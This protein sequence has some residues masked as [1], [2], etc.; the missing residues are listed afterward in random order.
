MAEQLT[1]DLCV[2]GAGTGGL[3]VAAGAALVGVSVVLIE[4]GR[5]GGGHARDVASKAL[6][7]AAARAETARRAARFGIDAEPEVD[8]ARV[9]A[10]VEAAAAGAALNH[11]EARLTAFG[12]KVVRGDAR[13][14]D[15]HTLVVGETEIRAA[16][17]V[18]ATGSS[19]ATPGIAGLAR[20]PYLT[21]ET[22]LGLKKLPAHLVV[23][24]AGSSGVE[25]AQAFRRLG[26]AV[27]VLESVTSLAEH[28]RECAAVVLDALVREDIALIMGD[29]RRVER[30][31]KNVRLVFAAAGGEETVEGSHLL[32][33]TGRR[34]NVDDLN[35]EAAGIA[36]DQRGI[37]VGRDLATTNKRVYALG[38]VTGAPQ[39][40]Q[41]A[42]FH[43][44]M[45]LRKLLFRRPID[46]NLEAVPRVT[47]TEPEL[48]HV[49]LAEAEARLRHGAIRVLRWPFAESDR[50]RAEQATEGMIKLVTTRGGRVVGA[51]I[52]GARAGELIAFFSLAIAKRMRT[53]ELAELRPAA[54]TYAEVIERVAAGSFLR[55][56]TN[57]WVRRIIRF[58][59]AR[60]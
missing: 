22:V 25:L 45:L 6:I 58:L 43:A 48:A 21:A 3:A 34:P 56:L 39:Y 24:G 33:A 53:G 9:R 11:S 47:F 52:V 32:V 55:R 59:R 36:F 14:A 20:V 2:I 16:R 13:F 54:L 46:V 35:L 60:G 31:R 8:F 12:V 1:P 50:A 23:L 15:P 30:V 5:F 57:P 17:F 44:T 10:H 51:S 40:A 27:T 49:G 26:A 28:D 38:D 42:T 18:V 29:P 7:A 37:H 41:V 4:R 19:P